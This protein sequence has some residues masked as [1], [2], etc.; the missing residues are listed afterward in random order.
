MS[1]RDR[2]I[3]TA[4]RLFSENGVTNVRSRDISAA[5]AIS[6]G[7][8][9]YHF[10]TIESLVEAIFDQM[11]QESSSQVGSLDS[12]G[13]DL[14]TYMRLIE[15]FASFQ[16]RYGFFYK[17]LLE[18]IRNY[19]RL[20][21]RYRSIISVRSEQ[22]REL[23]GRLQQA[24]VLSLTLSHERLQRLQAAISMTMTYWQAHAEVAVDECSAL[25]PE[26]MPAQVLSLLE[27]YL[28]AIGAEQRDAFIQS[29]DSLT[30]IEGY[31]S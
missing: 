16:A 19:P 10:P 28:T 3:E 21:S 13:R 26:G 5:L 25:S 7:N 30:G 14:I 27:P 31:K 17:D 1:T 8:L 11:L 6:N 12:G 9:T 4:Q 22:G 20:A 18:L 15:W 29:R 2:I 24:G 23:L